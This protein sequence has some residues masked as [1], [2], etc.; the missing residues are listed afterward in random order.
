MIK[1]ESFIHLFSH[2]AG[3]YTL[4]IFQDEVYVNIGF[5]FGGF[6]VSDIFCP[7]E[8]PNSH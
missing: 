4:N 7:L 6:T 5:S 2:A 8:T 1:P 3:R